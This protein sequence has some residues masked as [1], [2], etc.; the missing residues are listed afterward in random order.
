M[1]VCAFV[2]VCMYVCMYVCM[3]VCLCVCVIT[4]GRINVLARQCGREDQACH[5]A[6]PPL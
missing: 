2:C 6:L 4:G 3:C 1:C 5:H